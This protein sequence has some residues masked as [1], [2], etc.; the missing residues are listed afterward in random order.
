MDIFL[1][2]VCGYTMQQRQ[3]H[4]NWSE[5]LN[6]LVSFRIVSALFNME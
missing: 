3:S 2:D 5:A 4:K 1:L 6:Q